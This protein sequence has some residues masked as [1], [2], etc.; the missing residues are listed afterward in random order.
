[1][2][3]FVT[4]QKSCLLVSFIYTKIWWLGFIFLGLTKSSHWLW[5]KYSVWLFQC[6]FTFWW[7]RVFSWTK[8]SPVSCCHW[9]RGK[10]FQKC[11]NSRKFYEF[12]NLKIYLY[13]IYSISKTKSQFWGAG[14]INITKESSFAR[15]CTSIKLVIKLD[16]LKTQ[17]A[18]ATD[19]FA[20]YFRL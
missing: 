18:W 7:E 20:K 13:N 2:F 17:L 6:Q 14:R 12:F 16:L 8:F 19:R 11:F 9:N 3:S 15:K 4:I 5:F 10:N 1:M